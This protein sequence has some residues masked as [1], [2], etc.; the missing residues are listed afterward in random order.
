[1]LA[2]G[3]N[4]GQPE[5]WGFLEQDEAAALLDELPVPLLTPQHL[6]LLAGRWPQGEAEVALETLWPAGEVDSSGPGGS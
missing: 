3:K 2:Q 4:A 1:V 6:S 5:L